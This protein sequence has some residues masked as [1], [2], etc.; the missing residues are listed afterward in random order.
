MIWIHLIGIFMTVWIVRCTH[1][2][3][4]IEQYNT[5]RDSLLANYSSKTRPIKNQG[6]SLQM[7]MSLWISSINDVSAVNQKMVTTAYLN[8]K[9]KDEIITWNSAN[10]GIY[11]IQFNQNDLWIPDLVLKNGFTEFK[12]LGGKFYYVFV[13]YD[14][15]IHWYPYMVFES[16]CDID[17]SHYP[18]DKQT[19]N[20]I[21]K[22]WSYTRWEIN[23]TVSAEKVGFYE[24]VPN[25]VWEVTSTD[26]TFNLLSSQTDVTFVINLRRK[27][28]YYVLNLILPIL[29]LNILNLFVFIIP[30][31]TGEKMGFAVTIFLTFAVFLTMVSGE[32]PINSDSVSILSIYLII[33]LI[34]SVLILMITSLQ[35]R[36][37][38]RSSKRQIGRAYHSL[39][40][41]E[42]RLRCEPIKNGSELGC[43]SGK[44]ANCLKTRIKRIDVK[45]RE[46][47]RDKEKENV[48]EEESEL[49][50][51]WN[52]VSSAIDFFSFWVFLS[53]EF[54]ITTTIFSYASSD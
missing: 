40:Q 34:I 46:R 26:A 39:V 43:F 9:W 30:A 2:S 33:Q 49:E 27:S 11:W 31:D 52:D 14:G 53:L 50:T 1:L 25:S 16:I 4:T 35:L 3:Y 41:T 24:F 54:V 44:C 5:L 32:L 45:E 22:T 21:F 38:H 36:L 37:H 18:F 29:L 10:T 15:T 47:K 51:T 20:I 6:Q 7:Q 13:D 8:V 19:C 28:L 42:R 17:I 12:P 48:E 23:L